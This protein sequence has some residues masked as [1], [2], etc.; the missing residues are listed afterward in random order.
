MIIIASYA[1]QILQGKKK[2][3]DRSGGP[4]LNNYVTGDSFV[5][6]KGLQVQRLP[7]SKAKMHF[8]IILALPSPAFCWCNMIF[9]PK[10]Y[11]VC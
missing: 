11:G 2:T 6:D 9:G 10:S 7:D 8:Q 4:A 5:L 3:R 1:K